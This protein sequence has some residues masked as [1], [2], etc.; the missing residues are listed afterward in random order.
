MARH[1]FLSSRPQPVPRWTEA[2]PDADVRCGDASRDVDAATLAES[3]V[4]W[5]HVAEEGRTGADWVGRIRAQAGG[6]PVVVLSNVPEDDQGLAVL[7]AGAV[8]YSSALT[9]PEVL[10]QVAK[11]VENGGLWVGAPLMRRFMQSLAAGRASPPGPTLDQLSQ[12]E[13]Q[14]AEAA[15][16]GSTNKEIA[17]AMGITERTVKAHLSASFE[18]LGVRDRVQLALRIRGVEDSTPSSQKILA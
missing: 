8:G 9:L 17:R 12:R 14:V 10:R 6:T 11:V 13:R 1:L 4:I 18:K 5:L 2:F 7:A 3:A 16:R 15:A